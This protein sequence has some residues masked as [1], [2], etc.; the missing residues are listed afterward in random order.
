MVT[1]FL[2][3]DVFHPIYEGHFTMLQGNK[4]TG[5]PIVLHSLS[6]QFKGSV[7]T[8]K[9]NYDIQESY[10]KINEAIARSQ[11]EKVLVVIDDLVSFNLKE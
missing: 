10:Q 9:K 11:V 2:K 3:I 7:Y 5:I 6:I 4:H 1:G 8:I